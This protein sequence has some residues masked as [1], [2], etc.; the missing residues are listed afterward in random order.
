MSHMHLTRTHAQNYTALQAADPR[1]HR[2]RLPFLSYG[3]A[4]TLAWAEADG[5]QVV[6]AREADNLQHGAFYPKQSHHK[7]VGTGG[8]GLDNVALTDSSGE[9]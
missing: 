5:Q 4:L 2:C 9:W 7:V 6:G 8:P 1:P 3:I